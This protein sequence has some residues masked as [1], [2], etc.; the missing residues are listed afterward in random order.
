VSTA[1]DTGKYVAFVSYDAITGISRVTIN[2]ASSGVVLGYN[3]LTALPAHLFMGTVDSVVFLAYDGPRLV[4]AYAKG[5]IKSDNNQS[6][7][8]DSLP[9]GSVIDLQLLAKEGIEVKTL[10][11]DPAVINKVLEQLPNDL[12]E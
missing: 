10:S 7:R 6:T 9:V 12:R 11:D 4:V 1:A 5:D 3:A 2:Q 8:I